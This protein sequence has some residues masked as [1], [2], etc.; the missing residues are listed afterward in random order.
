MAE[1]MR[2][3][4]AFFGLH[5][6]LHANA[7]DTELGAETTEE[8]IRELIERVRPD[9]VQ[10]DCKG[11]PGY[12]C[13]PTEVGRTSPGVVRDSLA[14]LRKVSAEMGGNAGAVSSTRRRRGAP[15]WA[16]RWTASATSARQQYSRLRGQR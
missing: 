5:F 6:D 1:R 16:I 4:D 3:R 13:W 9:W 12:T 7:R 11:H 2:R 15:E 10:W 8:N 14:I